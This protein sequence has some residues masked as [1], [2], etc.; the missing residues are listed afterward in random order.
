MLKTTSFLA[1]AAMA[2]TLPNLTLAQSIAVSLSASLDEN[3]PTSV[4]VAAATGEFAVAS[5][6]ATASSTGAAAGSGDSSDLT[7]SASV[8]YNAEANAYETNVTFGAPVEVA[9]E[10]I[11]CDAVIADFG[12]ETPTGS[13]GE[14]ILAE[15][16]G[17]LQP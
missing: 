15:C 1:I 11:D 8:T 6:V 17:P 9:E 12:S 5:S 7:P 2:A 16:L 13:F 14:D 10:E 3:D 4:S